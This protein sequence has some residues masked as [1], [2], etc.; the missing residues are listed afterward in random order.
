MKTGF[1]KWCPDQELNLDQR[2]RNQI[3]HL[4]T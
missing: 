1:W 4:D 2:F 3:K